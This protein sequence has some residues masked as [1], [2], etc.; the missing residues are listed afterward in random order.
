MKKNSYVSRCVE[1]LLVF[2]FLS[3]FQF[4]IPHMSSCSYYMALEIR[5]LLHMGG[6][7]DLC[8]CILDTDSNVSSTPVC[9]Y[10]C[11]KCRIFVLSLGPHDMMSFHSE[12]PLKTTASQ[13]ATIH[14]NRFWP[15]VRIEW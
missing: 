13:E 15:A 1:G 6:R 7:K 9:C 3:I 11:M 10:A 14:K 2:K 12:Y 8:R 4:T 5:S